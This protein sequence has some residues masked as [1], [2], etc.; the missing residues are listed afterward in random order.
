MRL[1]PAADDAARSNTIM[2][3]TRSIVLLNRYNSMEET[4]RL[5]GHV[6]KIGHS[7]LHRSLLPVMR[8]TCDPPYSIAIAQA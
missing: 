3:Y 7:S 8:Q 6:Q 1:N 2:T 4:R 5:D